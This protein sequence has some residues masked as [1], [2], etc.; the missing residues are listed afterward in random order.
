[1]ASISAIIPVHN[2]FEFL[3]ETL[4]SVF[5][6]TRVPDEVLL[7]DD[8]SSSSPEDFLAQNPPPGPVKILHTDRQRN[9]SG[10]RNWGWQRAQ[11][12]LI[13]F[14][15]SDDLWEPD[16]TRMQAEYLESHPE[17]DGVYGAMVAFYPDGRTTPWA[18]DRPPVV[19]A[20]T[21]LTGAHMTTQTLMMRRQALEKLGGFDETLSILDD[22]VLAIDIGR[23]GLRV[24]FMPS[25]VVTRLRRNEK[26]FSRNASKYLF[27]ECRIAFRYR[28]LSA[29]VYGPGSV[30]VHLSRAVERF[31]HRTRFMNLPAKAAGYFLRALAPASRMPKAGL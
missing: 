18:H 4:A 20:A 11:G 25:P 3:N 16:K 23:V 19:D 10:A 24:V 5:S 12:D 21:A 15:D 30:L 17:V 14:D 22:E 29:A 31:G 2:R 8:L 27:E 13:A 28:K 7:V 9:V 26:N 1:M 6:Q